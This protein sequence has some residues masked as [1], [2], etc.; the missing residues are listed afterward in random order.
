MEV[1]NELAIQ[2]GVTVG[3]AKGKMT[4]QSKA[5]VETSPATAEEAPK[6]DERKN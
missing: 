6:A 3:H 4:V 1:N 5:L 2:G